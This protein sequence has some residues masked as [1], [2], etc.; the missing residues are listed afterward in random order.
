MRSSRGFRDLDEV[1]EILY[2]PLRRR[3]R[4]RLARELENELVQAADIVYLE[5]RWGL[6]DAP[7]PAE[8]SAAGAT[9]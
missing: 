6:E 3:N 5:E 4:D 7:E 2:E 9:E 1:Q 8:G